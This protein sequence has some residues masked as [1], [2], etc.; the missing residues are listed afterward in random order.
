MH[1]DGRFRRPCASSV[2]SILPPGRFNF[3]P[4]VDANPF[5]LG[6][7]LPRRW[8]RNASNAYSEVLGVDLP[9]W[10]PVIFAAIRAILTLTARKSQQAQTGLIISPGRLAIPRVRPYV[11][12][13]LRINV[14]S[15]DIGRVGFC[16]ARGAAEFWARRAPAR[17]TSIDRESKTPS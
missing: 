11:V 4:K 13:F 17:G 3:E 9:M 8:G 5:G 15:S 1:R 10:H 2:A 16:G 6:V 12:R 14:R 7:V